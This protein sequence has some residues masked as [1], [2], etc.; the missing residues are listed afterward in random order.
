MKN[1]KTTVAG[2]LLI[3]AGAATVV[4]ALL[5]T[6]DIQTALAGLMAALGGGGLVGAQDG[7]H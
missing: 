2:Y 7:G 1:K 5:G 6:G 3:A 4:A